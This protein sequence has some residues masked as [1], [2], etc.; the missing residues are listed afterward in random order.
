MARIMERYFE[1]RRLADIR[2]DPLLQGLAQLLV[3]SAEDYRVINWAFLDLGALV[4]K[5]RNPR[6]GECPLRRGCS[7]TGVANL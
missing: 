1:P 7:R 5:P 3:E 6:C 4:C 2:Y